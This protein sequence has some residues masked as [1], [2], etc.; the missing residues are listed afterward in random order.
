MWKWFEGRVLMRYHMRFNT[1]SVYCCI[2]HYASFASALPWGPTCA[3]PPGVHR[4][5]ACPTWCAIHAQED[6][7]HDHESNIHAHLRQRC[8]RRKHTRP[9][10]SWLLNMHVRVTLQKGIENKTTGSLR[11]YQ[12]LKLSHQ[13]LP[14]KKAYARSI[15]SWVFASLISS[16]DR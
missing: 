3:L 14:F 16:T 10:N 4:R 12:N 15:G 1:S 11:S 9:A 13:P 2:L 6:H 5:L 7:Y 8:T